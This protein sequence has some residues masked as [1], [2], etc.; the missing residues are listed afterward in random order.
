VRD[1]DKESRSLDWSICRQC[2][3]ESSAIAHPSLR[4]SAA[5][6]P[7]NISSDGTGLKMPLQTSIVR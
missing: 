5:Q 6:I 3:Q 7:W 2:Y 1:T 4:R